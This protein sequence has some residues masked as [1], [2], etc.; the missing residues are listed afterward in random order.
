MPNAINPYNFV[1]FYGDAFDE[2]PMRKKLS[3]YYSESDHQSGWLDVD[4]ITKSQVIVPDGANYEEIDLRRSDKKVHKEYSFFRHPDGICAIP[5]SE[6]RGMLRSVYEA[7]SN[8]CFPFLLEDK[9]PISQRTP[10]Y[11]AF[12]NRGLLGFDSEKK[13][14]RLY[15]TRKHIITTTKAA[16][17][18]GVFCQGGVEYHTAE[19]VTFSADG[20]KVTLG[21]G[22]LSGFLQF[23]IPVGP[24]VYHIAVLE[25]EELEHEWEAGDDDAY[26]S[27]LSSVYDTVKNVGPRPSTQGA[28][29]YALERAARGGKNLVPVYYFCVKRVGKPL[30]YLSGAA[31]GRVHQKR[32]WPDIM[33]EH[34][35]CKSLDCLCPACALFGTVRGDGA[36]G[37]LRVT[38]AR[39]Q[40]ELK[41]ER[42]TL[43]ILGGPRSSSFEFYLRRPKT[44]DGDIPTYWN[45]DYYGVRV[46]YPTHDGKEAERTEYHD[47]PTATP[48]G[49]KFYWHGNQRPDRS[50]KDHMNATMEAVDKG[51]V[52]RFRI[53]FD[54]ITQA[55]LD[56]LLWTI[57]LG[58]NTKDSRFQHKLGHAK[59]LGYGSVKMVV[60]DCVKRSVSSDFSVSV[61]HVAVPEK[62]ACAFPMESRTIQS[63]LSISDCT[64]TRGEN[65]EYLTGAGKVR[66]EDVYMIYNWF[67]KNRMNADSLLTLPEPWE[68]NLSLPTKR[69]ARN[70]SQAAAPRFTQT[71]PQRKR[72]SEADLAEDKRKYPTGTVLSGTVKNVTAGNMAFFNL[73]GPT[74][75]G[76]LHSGSLHLVRGQKLKLK[77]VGYYANKEKGTYSIKVALAE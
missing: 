30:Y 26:R 40:A 13:V 55:Q 21:S 17:E 75:D 43:E 59:P 7:A 25:P 34:A 72:A 50:I 46:K 57:T 5:G 4:L 44:N 12:K 52:F 9:K 74:C 68:R 42:H 20:D 15:R 66:G 14:W 1:P 65:V 16:V 64:A 36:K 47:L 67:Q 6:L 3:E 29:K 28:L 73:D 61:E 31:V 37:Q 51:A 32:K 49:R 58:E 19:K 62:T 76:S 41:T 69:G 63:I 45:Y 54:R 8:S 24:G 23:N 39:A 27:I 35:P 38:D 77:V 48:R 53:Y 60:T 70:Q 10:I 71:K 22:N 11:G 2:A 33:G 18:A 56:E